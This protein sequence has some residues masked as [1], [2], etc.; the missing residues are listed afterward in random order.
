MV[1]FYKLQR[2]FPAQDW[3]FPFV[4]G[5]G[6]GTNDELKLIQKLSKLSW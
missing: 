6:S 4:L 2:V 1:W 3:I 5:R